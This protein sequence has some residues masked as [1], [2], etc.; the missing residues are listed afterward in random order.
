MIAAPAFTIETSNDD[1]K[2]QQGHDFSLRRWDEYDLESILHLEPVCDDSYDHGYKLRHYWVPSTIL[3]YEKTTTSVGATCTR[4]STQTFERRMVR[5]RSYECTWREKTWS[6]D[7]E[8]SEILC[9]YNCHEQALRTCAILA[10]NYEPESDEAARKQTISMMPIAYP[11]GPVAIGHAWHIRVADDHMNFLFSDAETAENGPVLVV[12]RDGEFV[13]D[14]AQSATGESSM[15]SLED[16]S[17]IRVRR[18][19]LTLL[20]GNRGVVLQDRISDV[21]VEGNQSY[22]VGTRSEIIIRLMSSKPFES[23]VASTSAVT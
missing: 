14:A 10:S 3:Q 11:P 8:M 6:S 18:E 12:R 13:L 7:G 15:S 22:P 23:D 9:C 4:E 5:R 16:S 19:G 20:S 2:S 1:S 17:A 21:V